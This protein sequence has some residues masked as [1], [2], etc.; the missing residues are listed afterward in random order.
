MGHQARAAGH[1]RRALPPAFRVR[2][3]FRQRV[4]LSWAHPA[5]AGQA[6]TIL[7]RLP[8]PGRGR[9]GR[10]RLQGQQRRAAAQPPGECRCSAGR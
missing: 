6:A 3:A 1:L 8:C 2:Q 10:V 5:S 4:R 7:H 9:T